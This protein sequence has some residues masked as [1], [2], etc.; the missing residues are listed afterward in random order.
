MLYVQYS[1][2]RRTLLYNVYVLYSTGW[3]LLY[4]VHV[5]CFTGWT[6]LC[7]A[8][9]LYATGWTLPYSVYVV[10]CTGWTL[11]YYVHVLC[12]CVHVCK[13]LLAG[14]SAYEVAPRKQET[15]SGTMLRSQWKGG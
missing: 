2:G 13:I 4:N 8:S 6:L 7:S 10:Y 5:Q 14:R 9:M 12:V 1:T 3:T 15:Q 11:L